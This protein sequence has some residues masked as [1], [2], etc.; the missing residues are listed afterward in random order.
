MPRGPESSIDVRTL[1]RALA[2]PPPLRGRLRVEIEDFRVDE[3][4]PYEPSGEGE[5]LFVHFEKRDLTTPDAVRRIA[6]ALG[7][8]PKDAG[9]AGLK[10]R[11]A[12]TRQW[13]SFHRADADAAR[14]LSVD[15]VTILDARPHGHKLRTGHVRA[16][17]FALV[18]RGAVDIEA[19]QRALTQLEARGVPNYF[20]EQRFGRFGDNARRAHA[21]LVGG[22]RGPR[23][24]HERKLL[25]SSLQ[26]AI[27]NELLA[28]RVAANTYGAAQAGDLLQKEDSGGLFVCTDA[29]IDGARADAFEVSPTGPMFGPKMRWPEGDVRTREEAALARWGLDASGLDD[30]K[31]LGP[32]TRRPYRTRVKDARV[33]P[34]PEGATVHLTL[35][36]GV[37]AT[38]VMRELL[39]EP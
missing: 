14:A 28:D 38:V 19:T 8:N 11:R 17:R 34:H 4:I 39:A 6:Q 5:H 27:F 26:S 29:A 9:W 18:V 15:A 37:Y 31:T 16:N 30:L 10:D 12:V 20:G 2:T 24:R 36:S 32:G 13:A 25:V 7:V 23:A 3:T 35:D 1:P 21:W 22:Q 33:E